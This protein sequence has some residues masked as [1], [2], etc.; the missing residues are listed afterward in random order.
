VVPLNGEF[1]L[2]CECNICEFIKRSAI[3]T[4]LTL[5][6]WPVPFYYAPLQSDDR[7]RASVSWSCEGLG[8]WCRGGLW[9]V[10]F[11]SSCRQVKNRE[12]HFTGEFPLGSKFTGKVTQSHSGALLAFQMCSCGRLD[13][14]M[15][16]FRCEQWQFCCAM[17]SAP[18]SP[19]ATS[20]G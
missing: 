14:W 18:D 2:S 4:L 15:H 10:R 13:L 16:K 12:K 8:R 11:A 19:M 9:C 1:L 20:D 7:P 6:F 5:P 3:Q 17:T